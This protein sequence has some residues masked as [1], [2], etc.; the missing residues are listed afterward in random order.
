MRLMTNE[1]LMAVAGGDAA[2]TRSGNVNSWGEEYPSQEGRFEILIGGC[3]GS[4]DCMEA[5]Y[6]LTH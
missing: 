5:M 3:G 6:D 1:E 2:E 4:T